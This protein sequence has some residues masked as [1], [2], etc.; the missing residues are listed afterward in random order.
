MAKIFLDSDF[1][2]DF[3]NPQNSYFHIV[4]TVCKGYKFVIPQEVYTELS[5]HTKKQLVRTRIDEMLNAEEV[6]IFA[7]D[8]SDNIAANLKYLFTNSRPGYKRIGAGEA[9]AIALC[10]VEK[11]ILASNNLRDINQYVQK[12]EIKHITSYEVICRAVEIKEITS[13]EAEEIWSGMIAC[14]RRMPKQTFREF[15]KQNK[16]WPLN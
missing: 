15:K 9:A 4:Q 11:G 3:L 6:E 5:R 10:I 16:N 1:L 12:H 2:I 14:G 13:N 7:M 8:T